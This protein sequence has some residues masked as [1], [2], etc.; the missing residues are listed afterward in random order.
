MPLRLWLYVGAFI[1]AFSLV[2]AA[3]IVALVLL[4]GRDVPG[5]ASLIVAVMFFGGVQ[6]LSIGLIG[7]YI[8]RIFQEIKGRPIYLIDRI[9]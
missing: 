3:G 1:C 6:L 4:T 2:Y 5:Y 8:G 9:E 7:E